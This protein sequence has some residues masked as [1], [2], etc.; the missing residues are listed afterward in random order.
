MKCW[1]CSP[2]KLPIYVEITQLA[3]ALRWSGGNY[4][5]LVSEAVEQANST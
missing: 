1:I 4:E 2:K 3:I 5:E